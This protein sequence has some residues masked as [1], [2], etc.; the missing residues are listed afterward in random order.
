[1]KKFEKLLD[2]FTSL[3]RL[4]PYC[5]E[6]FDSKKRIIE[7]VH[8]YPLK[9]NILFYI[10]YTRWI[11]RKIDKS[12]RLLFLV[13]ASFLHT[14]RKLFERKK[15]ERKRKRNFRKNRTRKRMRSRIVY[16]F[17][18]LYRKWK[19]VNQHER[20]LQRRKTVSNTF[21]T[22]LCY[23]FLPPTSSPVRTVSNL[24]ICFRGESSSR[25]R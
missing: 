25:G 7:Y 14:S 22:F 10:L 16:K 19:Y 2:R 8:F 21:S 11:P 17:L 24:E 1:M 5:N 9:T 13:R 4:I 20:E 23:R 15:E 18:S 3:I 12:S 6:L